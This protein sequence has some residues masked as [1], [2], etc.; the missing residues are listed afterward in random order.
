MLK[1][2]KE[3]NQFRSEVE[4]ALKGIAEKYNFSIEAGGI[5]YDSLHM[6]LTLKVSEKEVNG[7]SVEQLEFEKYCELFNLEKSDYLKKFVA[8]SGKEFTLYGFN[9]RAKSMP[10]LA[11]D[12]QGN[13]YKFRELSIRNLLKVN[14]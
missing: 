4:E 2:K 9:L 12:Q 8:S 6:D 14:N 5:K 7:K 13:S 1:G 10:I 11:R 3:F